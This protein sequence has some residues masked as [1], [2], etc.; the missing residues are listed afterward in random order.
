MLK[1][2]FINQNLNYELSNL[3]FFIHQ[4]IENQLKMKYNENK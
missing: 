2:A 3:D 4:S 1:N